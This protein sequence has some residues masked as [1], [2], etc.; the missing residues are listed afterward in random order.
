M[1][2]FHPIM[3][4]LCIGLEISLRDLRKI[5]QTFEKHNEIILD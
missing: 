4:F 2:I 3:I 5:P 1:V